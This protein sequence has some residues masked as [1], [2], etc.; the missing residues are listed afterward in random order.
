MIRATTTFI[1]ALLVAAL[2]AAPARTAERAVE[3]TGTTITAGDSL[4]DLLAEVSRMIG[5]LRQLR[6]ELAEARLD[7]AEARREAAELRQ[8]I[9]DH[10]E[11]GDDFEQYQAVKAVTEREARQREAER[12]RARLEQQRTEQRERYEQAKAQREA[13]E[14]EQR[15]LE[16][17]ADAGFAPLG[18]DVFGGRMAFSYQ[19]VGT[20]PIRVDYDITIGRYL[21]PLPPQR[22]IDF[23]KMTISGSI[24]NA[25]EQTRNVGVAIVFFDQRGN[26]VGSETIQVNNARPDVPYPFTST[27]EM[28]LNRPFDS[29]STYVLYADPAQASA[30]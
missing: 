17:Y 9:A 15:R 14:A 11:Y 13:E 5:E 20:N 18:L 23:S 25:A 3:P 30:D 10:R 19:T 22:Q 2:F 12:N 24:L 8:F 4:D 16:R 1:A 28:A 26:Q 29:S 7:A 6:K 21:R 27:I